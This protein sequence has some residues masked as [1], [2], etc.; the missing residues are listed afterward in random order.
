M[1]CSQTRR[2]EIETM[3]KSGRSLDDRTV[4]ADSPRDRSLRERLDTSLV[5]CE[6]VLLSFFLFF[7]SFVSVVEKALSCYAEALAD[8]LESSKH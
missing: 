7:F 5:V 8:Q 3:E 2:A 4:A 6:V 1:F